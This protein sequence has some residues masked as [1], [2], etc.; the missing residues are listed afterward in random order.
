MC[1]YAWEEGRSEE[2]RGGIRFG[3]SCRGRAVV[4]WFIVG[5]KEA[6]VPARGGTDWP[7]LDL[8]DRLRDCC[9]DPNDLVPSFQAP[10]V[11]VC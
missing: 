1:G 7:N 9:L 10:C 2:D 4:S 8:R 5:D 6:C 3:R 11:Q